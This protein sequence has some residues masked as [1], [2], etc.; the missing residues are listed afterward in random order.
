MNRKIFLLICLIST[1]ICTKNF[2]SKFKSSSQSKSVASLNFKKIPIVFHKNY[3]IS[4]WG[5]EKLHPFDSCKYGKIADYI[6]KNC[7]IDRCRFYTPD[8]VTDN[9]L[10][11]VHSKEYLK[12]VAEPSYA[13][14][15]AEV[16]PLSWIPRSSLQTRL[17][18]PMR[19]ATGGTILACQLALKFGWA[20]NLSG[21]YHHAKANSGEGFCFFADIPLAVNILWQKNP[22]LKVMVVDLDAHQGNGVESI[23]KNDKRI[24]VFDVYNGQIYPNDIEAKK[25]IRYNHPIKGF[26]RD[27]QYL[28]LVKTELP[29]ALD[30]F[31]P[32]LIIY[33]AGTDIFQEDPLGCLGVSEFGIIQ[34]DSIVFDL[35]LQRNKPVAMLLS[36]GYSKKTY[37]IIGKSIQNILKKSKISSII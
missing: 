28:N 14:K 20:I 27:E 19:Y 34:R 16:K 17:L 23:L 11:L 21:G 33:N 32:D 4:F 36:G 30:Q 1:N 10:L 26:T 7:S 18:D 15:V 3:D 12:K 2:F 37:E 5:L 24:A 8:P 22:N 6:V 29:K 9:E 35:C 13:A 25:Y 31:K